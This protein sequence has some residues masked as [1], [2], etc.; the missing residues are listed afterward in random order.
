M[1]SYEIEQVLLM[2]LEHIDIIPAE[3][4][5]EHFDVAVEVMRSIHLNDVP[6]IAD[7]LAIKADRIW[8]FDEHFKKQTTVRVF[9]TRNLSNL[10]L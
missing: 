9:S 1:S 3:K 7:A 4:V 8:S 2:L 6:F 10:N 5:K